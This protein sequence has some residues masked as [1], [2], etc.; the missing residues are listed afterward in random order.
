MFDF[1]FSEL[2]VIGVVMLVVVG[3]ERLPKVARTAGHLLGRVQRYVSDVKSDIQREMQ[4]DELKKLQEQ[5]K[6]QA[7]ELESSVRAG[8]AG[9]ESEVNRTADEVRSMMPDAG[10]SAASAVA[11]SQLLGQTASATAAP[12]D[13]QLELGL[14]AAAGQAAAV[15]AAD[16]TKA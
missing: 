9:V 3:P 4:L 13:T 7:Q 6:Q 11:A 5:V 2:I 14:D 10:A 15:S 1:G 16:K 12:A 8:A